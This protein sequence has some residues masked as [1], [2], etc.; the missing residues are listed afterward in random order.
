MQRAM[1]VEQAADDPA[2]GLDLFPGEVMDEGLINRG[3]ESRQQDVQL[4]R[5]YIVPAQATPLGLRQI[6]AQSWG[7]LAYR[8]PW[9]QESSR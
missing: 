1:P 2:V 4:R 5:L 9:E 7:K 8:V 6:G 3:P